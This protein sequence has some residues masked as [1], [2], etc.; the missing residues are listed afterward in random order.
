MAR[1]E[2]DKDLLGIWQEATGQGD[3]GLRR[4]ME[5]AVQRI[6][7]EEL[8]SFLQAESHERTQDRK[9]YRNGYKP[10]TLTTRLGRMDLLI[11]KDREGR[12]QTELFERYQRN[13]KALMLSLVEMYV[14]GVST[15]KVKAVTE[16]LCGLD[17][18]KSQVS[19]L[20]KD[21]DEEVRAWRSRPLKKKYPYLVVDARYEKIR[22]NHQVL[23]QGVLLVVGIGEDG[24]R[25]ILGTWVADSENEAS[26]SGVFKELK[27]R[28]LK[29]VRYV[30]S[31]DHA[32][33]IKA[34]ARHFQGVLWQRCQVHFLRNIIFQV[35]KKDRPRIIEMVREIMAA[36]THES[37]R[38]RMDEVIEALEKK[39]PKVSQVLEEHGEDILTVYQLPL[40][41]RRSLKS[42]NMLERYNQELKRRTRVVR[43]FPHQ[44]SCLRLVTAMAMEM[45]E[46]WMVRRYLIFEDEVSGRSTKNLLAA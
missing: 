23:P 10:R 39:H 26:W 22:I 28:G 5:T 18:S 3:D 20:A 33:L 27:E 6:L 41:H 16:A 35:S 46:E 40:H 4:V 44:E 9:G 7:E 30:V 15:R 8:T 29:G 13:E 25:E 14:H 34:I 36:Q 17:I 19:R 43:I 38:K 2:D 21:L 24:Y 11:P 37:A 45:S 32:G 42:T 12:F 31:D 1:R